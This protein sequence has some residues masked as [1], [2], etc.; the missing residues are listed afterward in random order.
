MTLS[1]PKVNVRSIEIKRITIDKKQNNR[2]LGYCHFRHHKEFVY[3][4]IKRK[5]NLITWWKKA[6]VT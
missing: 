3:P 6:R 5:Y 4:L 2:Q 1:Q